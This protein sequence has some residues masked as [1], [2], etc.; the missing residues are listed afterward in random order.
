MLQAEFCAPATSVGH[1]AAQLQSATPHT[2][3]TALEDLNIGRGGALEPLLQTP[4]PSWQGPLK[5]IRLPLLSHCCC[6]VVASAF[7][8]ARSRDVNKPPPPGPPV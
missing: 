1:S 4:S 8:S 2:R 3:R 7:H 6:N 5:P